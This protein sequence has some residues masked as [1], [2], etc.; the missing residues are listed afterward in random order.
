MCARR[1]RFH[2][3]ES[4]LGTRVAPCNEKGVLSFGQ[5]SEDMQDLLSAGFWCASGERRHVSIR[6][7]RSPLA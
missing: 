3:S 7:R 5:F 2:N 1:I 4:R 6:R